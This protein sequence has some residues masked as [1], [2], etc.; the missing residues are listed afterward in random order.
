MLFRKPKKD[1]APLISDEELINYN[2]VLD[3]LVGLSADDYKKVCAVAQVYREADQ[4]A[5]AELGIANEPSTFIHPP[6]P[7][8]M[9][10]PN[11]LDELTETPKPKKKIAVKS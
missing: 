3:W 5:A 1:L 10:E 9:P 4:K 2:S 6:E 11:F 8:E 7:E